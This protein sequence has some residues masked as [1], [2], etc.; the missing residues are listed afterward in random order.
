MVKVIAKLGM[1]DEVIQVPENTLVLDLKKRLPFRW[2]ENVLV[3]I[4]GKI[5]QNEQNLKAIDRVRVLPI[6][7]GG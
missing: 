5:A 6:I 1:E 7:A 3:I 4:N 2:Q